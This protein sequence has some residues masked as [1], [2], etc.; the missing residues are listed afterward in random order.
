MIGFP[1]LGS[2]NPED[3]SVIR[4]AA[5]T[6]WDFVPE[7]LKK[8]L[9]KYAESKW[10]SVVWKTNAEAYLSALYARVSTTRLLGHPKE[11]RLSEI[12]TDVYIYDSPLEQKRRNPSALDATALR[13][14]R[15]ADEEQRLP[16]EAILREKRIYLTGKPGAGKT[17]LLRH[18]VL[19]SI[20]SN[21]RSTP[22]YVAL[23]DISENVADSSEIN[24]W[25]HIAQQFEIA[26]LPNTEE[27]LD[28]L[29][30]AGRAVLLLDGLDEVTERDGIR[31][32]LIGEILKIASGYPKLQVILTC[33]VGAELFTFEKFAVAQ[34]ADFSPQQ[35]LSFVKRWYSDD[36]AALRSFLDAWALP[37]NGG[38]RD[39][40][41]TPLLLALLCI[42]YDETR[43]FPLR[44]G[45]LYKEAV[46][47]LLRRWSVSRGI[48]RDNP[49]RKLTSSRKEQMLAYVAYTLFKQGH[50]I[51]SGGTACTVIAQY[52]KSLPRREID[53]GL[54]ANE[55][56]RNL[57]AAHGLV[58]HETSDYYAFS[59][60]TIHEYFV[61]QYLI[62]STNEKTLR[63]ELSFAN[64]CNRQWREIILLA[65]GSVT[66]ADYILLLIRGEI[67][68]ALASEPN[69]KRILFA[70]SQS[71]E[72]A[73]SE[74]WG[75]WADDSNPNISRI[76]KVD[77]QYDTTHRSII[78][79][80][81]DDLKRA[82]LLASSLPSVTRRAHIFAKNLTGAHAKWVETYLREAPESR[83]KKFL[84]ILYAES[85]YAAA[86]A[87][88]TVSDRAALEELSLRY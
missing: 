72:V 40:A 34:I 50:F 69:M 14:K 7:R 60:L 73:A 10:A 41:S 43:E 83:R 48:E 80:L 45:D 5:K 82:V 15:Q 52:L 75:A 84:E 59:H 3:I 39:L 86:L 68:A 76:A 25:R 38:L 81:T 77:R 56:L 46:E 71:E 22:I 31:R 51:F 63:H 8:K 85:L 4:E 28:H 49:Y 21:K 33:R 37:D 61:A 17:T 55:V 32:T 30:D 2:L 20:A 54:E 53:D 18:L 19:R 57:E 42:G 70:L 16:A 58:V 67:S 24:L 27:F 26:K 44:R 47:A 13:Q 36:P 62:D 79:R 78:Q 11:I 29:M 9:E 1:D 87:I 6:A 12:F 65:A 64:I 66:S 35:Q 74:V 88:G 23:K